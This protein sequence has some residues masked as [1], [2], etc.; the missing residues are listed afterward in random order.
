MATGGRVV[1]HLAHLAPEPRNLILLP[2]F[3]VA[4]TRGRALLDGARTLKMYGGYVPVRAEVVGV[5]DFSAHADADGLLAW[6]KTA[7][8]PP[9]TCYVVHGEPPASAALA[10]RID[11]ELGWCAVR[12][13]QA[14][15][16]LV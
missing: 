14:E 5:D 2:G 8:A 10:D 11:R 4:G 6:L 15:R 3:Q 7:P 13:R 1:H 12:P 9:R 16:V